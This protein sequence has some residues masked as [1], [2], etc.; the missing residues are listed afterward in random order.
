MT[1]KLLIF[2]INTF[3]VCFVC[4]VVSKWLHR[5]EDKIDVLKAY[6]KADVNLRRLA[7]VELLER[8]REEAIKREDSVVAMGIQRLINEELERMRK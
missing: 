8:L 1:G 2:V 4:I 5:M 3:C 6:I 7:Y